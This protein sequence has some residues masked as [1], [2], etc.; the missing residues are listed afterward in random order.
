M[1]DGR[2]LTDWNKWAPTFR[3]ISVGNVPV[4]PWQHWLVSVCVAVAIGE[5]SLGQRLA[6][7]ERSLEES[8]I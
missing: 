2:N 5:M 4:C 6:I 1:Q 3:A 8:E 7:M